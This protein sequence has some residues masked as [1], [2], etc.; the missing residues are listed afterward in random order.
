VVT[1]AAVLLH[2][3][4]LGGNLLESDAH[5]FGEL[6]YGRCV[7]LNAA[8]DLAQPRGVLFE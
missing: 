2:R 7:P 1:G 5:L 3:A 4:H 8:V 6:L